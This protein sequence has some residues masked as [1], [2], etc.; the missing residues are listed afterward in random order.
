M[1]DFCRVAVGDDYLALLNISYGD[2][3]TSLFLFAGF[4]ISNVCLIYL[5]T[6]FPL[7]LP[8]FELV[9]GG[10]RKRA[11]EIAE[12]ELLR[13]EAEIEGGQASTQA[14]GLLT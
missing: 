4:T 14:T 12:E 6:F 8:S 3:W 10:S 13:E 5:F 1:C 9:T 2:R 7:R 11:A